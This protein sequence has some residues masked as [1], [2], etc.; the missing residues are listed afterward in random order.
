M[1][2]KTKSKRPPSAAS[3][4]KK[5]SKQI[6]NAGVASRINFLSTK[7]KFLIFVLVFAIA[8]GVYFVY[9]SSAA[10]ASW[11]YTVGNKQ[12]ERYSNGNCGQGVVKSEQKK[13]TEVVSIKCSGATGSGKAGVKD[14]N[15]YITDW[16]VGKDY[17]LCVTAKTIDY[18][19]LLNI[20][21]TING[22]SDQKVL[23]T[24]GGEY[25]KGNFTTKCTQ[26]A[27]VLYAGDL[28]LK[29][30]MSSYQ[31]KNMGMEIASMT[32]EMK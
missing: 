15:A 25:V 17:R 24:G 32:L 18:S 30:E 14:A 27:R 20:S 21:M 8:G 23:A 19:P 3:N 22:K 5:T 26:Y 11:V 16:L 4:S 12:L 7:M 9:M 6:Q 28:V 1:N 31:N 29:A 2:Q 10:T 13:S